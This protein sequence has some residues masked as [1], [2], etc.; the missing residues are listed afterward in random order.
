M[1][2]R[3]VIQIASQFQQYSRLFTN[4]AWHTHNGR[5][6]GEMYMHKFRLAIK[7]SRARDVYAKK[8]R[9]HYP[10]QAAIR[11]CIRN[12]RV[13]KPLYLQIQIT[14]QQGPLHFALCL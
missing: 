10:L 3:Q 12:R 2:F 7:N 4:R 14:L 5:H 1:L 11:H 8:W 13:S 6:K 9:R